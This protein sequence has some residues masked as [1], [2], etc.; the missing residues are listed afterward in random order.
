MIYTLNSIVYAE[1]RP[2]QS[3]KD[4]FVPPSEFLCVYIKNSFLSYFSVSKSTYFRFPKTDVYQDSN[5]VMM[6]F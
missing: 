2:T 5:N 1:L 4:L 6:I 3:S